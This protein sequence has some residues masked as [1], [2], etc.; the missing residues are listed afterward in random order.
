M[1]LD[2]GITYHTSSSRRCD[3]S[4]EITLEKLVGSMMTTGFQATNVGLAVEEINR[5][6]MHCTMRR[7]STA[8]KFMFPS[9]V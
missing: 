3:F 9:R 4:E 6:V 5:M 7:H 2:S 8:A 1:Y